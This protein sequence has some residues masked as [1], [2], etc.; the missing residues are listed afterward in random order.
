MA[1]H[2]SAIIL[3]AGPNGLG[4]VRGLA[5]GG[6]NSYLITYVSNDPA[7]CSRYPVQKTAL[8]GNNPQEKVSELTKLLDAALPGVVV[9]PTSDW[10]VAMLTSYCEAHP[11][12]FK[13]CM[14]SQ[15]VSAM[16]IDKAL[17]TEVMQ[18]VASLPKT[19]QQLPQTPEELLQ[20]LRL[21]I[22][23]KPRS[24]E[25]YK[26]K[27]KT[28][29]VRD[30]AA[31]R[32][33][34]KT[35]GE[36]LASTIAQEIIPGDDSCLW[37]CNCTFNAE[38][39]LADAF[40][41]AISEPNSVVLQQVERIGAHIK[42]VGPAMVEFKFDER[43]NDYKYIELNP[44]LGMCNFFDTCCGVNNVLNTYRLAN[45][46]HLPAKQPTQRDGVIFVSLYEDFFSRRLDGQPIPKILSTYLA[47]FFKPHVFIYFT[48]FDPMPALVQLWRNITG[49]AKSLAKKITKV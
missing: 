33:F 32:V 46:E 29:Q 47:D 5:R 9:I 24:F 17:E 6:V 23:F 4:A 28:I 16:V 34:Y 42:F 39:K 35:F 40:V 31:L 14:P 3:G 2:Y 27:Q 20:Q 10:F 45:G 48:L 26:L 11:G 19:V 41:Y 12:R 21:P 30:M 49:I 15:Q 43:D 38:H 7:L 8:S 37:V 13:T 22:I 1:T 36:H 44:R 18:Q 25:H